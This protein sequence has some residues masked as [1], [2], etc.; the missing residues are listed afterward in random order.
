[1]DH[2]SF[3]EYDDV[4]IPIES[5]ESL[6]VGNVVYDEA[7][8]ARQQEDYQKQIQQ[9]ETTAVPE[10]VRQF[11]LYFQKCFNEGNA[12]ELHGCYETSFQKLTEKFYKTSRWPHPISVVAPLVNNDETFVLFYTEVYYRHVYARFQPTLEERS[13]SYSN[14]CNLFNFIL[15]SDNALNLE[16][17]TNWVWDIIDE[18]IYQFNS[19]SLY[20]TKVL[21]KESHETEKAWL[22]DHDKVWDTYSVLNVLYSLCGKTKIYEQLRAQ[23]NGQDS[24]EV[25]GEYGSRNLFKNFGYFCIIGLLRVHTIL[26]DYHLALKTLEGVELNKRSPFAR[27]P[28]AHFTTYYYVGFCYLMCRRYA[29]AVKSFSHILLY[30]ARTKNI[31]RS[32]QFDMVNKRS[33][34]M[35]ALLAISV[36]LS[37]TRLDDI[38]NTG[39]RERY[40]DQLS[41]L[42]RGGPE[43]YPVFEELFLKSAPR[44]IFPYTIDFE[45]TKL[46]S[47]ATKHHLDIFMVE[48]KNTTFA[49]NL[50]SYLNLYSTMDLGKLAGFL[51]K[52]PEEL[53]SALVALKVKNRQL[54]RK[55][56]EL[57]EGEYVNVSELDISLENDLIH[58]A[59]AKDNRKFADW[60][61]R[62]TLKNYAVQEAIANPEKESDNVNKN[63][64]RANKENKEV[65]AEKK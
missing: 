1:M 33:D 48:V 8:L 38:V 18:F 57:L 27:F 43:S 39:L 20:R 58:I 46:N 32:V 56:G 10:V 34:Q 50:K 45:S 14:Y 61:I 12:Y 25:A 4:N 5:D 41:K 23:K 60:F 31:N 64:K 47:D 19:F 35:Y 36:A 6:A 37:P 49:F 51:E 63:K 3:N 9:A 16:I 17:P 24:T 59:E 54:V 28:S 15:N 53:R 26:G 44:F 30:I 13:L 2:E 55:D 65:A 22:K 11:L 62:N 40:G 21:K 52:D 29:D 7:Q 42:Q